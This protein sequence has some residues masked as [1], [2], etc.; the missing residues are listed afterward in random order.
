VSPDSVTLA[1]GGSAQLGVQARDNRGAVMALPALTWQSLTNG[2][3]VSGAGLVTAAS[4]IGNTIADG[5]VQ[6]SGGGITTRV[7]VAV[8]VV[9]V[10]PPP[11]DNGYVQIRWIGTQPSAAV[12]AAF[13][14]QRVRI[15]GLFKGFSGV[16][17]T[18]LNIPAGYCL[19]GSPAIN[20]TVPGVI[21]YAQVAPIDGVGNI[22]GSAGPCLVRSGSL[23]PIVGSMMFDVA[24]MNSMASNGTLNGVVLHEMMH[25]L[26]FGTIWGPGGQNEVASPSGVD[27]RYLGTSG[28]VA[29]GALGASDAA[30]GVP[31]EN[32]GGSG[33]RGSHW[34]ESVFHTELMTGWADGALPMSRVTI[35]ALKDFGYDVDLTKADP[36][37]LAASL[38]GAGLRASV[39]I[40]EV[41]PVPIGVVGPGGKIS[42][43]NGTIAH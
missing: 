23:L 24:D 26:G 31:V 27:P 16:S 10:P 36:F 5:A 9:V 43:F 18:D 34:R 2:I 22:L 15:N 3:S 12:L 14:A 8:V 29:Y 25:I 19:A 42:P 38:I 28:L 7:R 40:V 35:A 4:N 41:N 33:T 32:T 37:T 6:V 30:T 21:I 1:P 11:S 20:E 13:E 39:E 17:A